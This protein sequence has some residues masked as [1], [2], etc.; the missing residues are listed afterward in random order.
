MSNA[1]VEVLDGA[2]P[3]MDIKFKITHNDIIEAMIDEQK[4][5]AQEVIDFHRAAFQAHQKTVEELDEA[6]T[7]KQ[8]K[9]AVKFF[10]KMGNMLK[11]YYPDKKLS[12]DATPNIP[13][14]G[15]LKGYDPCM[16]VRVS[17]CCGDTRLASVYHVDEE[18]HKEE[19]ERRKKEN[20]ETQRLGDAL[21]NA[22]Q[23]KV[24]LSAS[25]ATLKREIINRLLAESPEGQK[26]M[27]DFKVLGKKVSDQVQKKLT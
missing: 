7:E 24:K 17:M 6:F 11:K 8:K 27:D 22:N 19:K 2:K 4:E 21:N 9:K 16:E 1:K 14:C 5:K 23:V 20:A 10:T 13:W 25:K 12:M 15:G 3:K 26:F 18:E